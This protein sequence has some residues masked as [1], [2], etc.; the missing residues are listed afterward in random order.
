MITKKCLVCEKEFQCIKT[1]NNE[2]KYC[3]KE[4]YYQMKRIRKDKVVWTDEMRKKMSKKYKGKGNPM[5]GKTNWCKGK[6]RP[7][8]TGDKHPNYKGGYITKEGYLETGR[9]LMKHRLVMEEYLGRKLLSTE[10]IHHIDRDKLNNN[11]KNL[12]L[13]TR[14]EHIEIHRADLEKGKETI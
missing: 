12:M 8:M 4:C 2:K 14:A 13:C 11:I 3:S 5:Y 9:H 6:K 1:K 7:E 10:I